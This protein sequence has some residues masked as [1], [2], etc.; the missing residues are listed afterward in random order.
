MYFFY[1][2]Y[3]AISFNHCK[4]ESKAKEIDG[5]WFLSKHAPEKDK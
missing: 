5:Y 4:G 1:L 3:C 2:K